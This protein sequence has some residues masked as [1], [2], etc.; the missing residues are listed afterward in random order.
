MGYYVCR[1]VL[2]AE[3]FS[4]SAK[5]FK[6]YEFEDDYKISLDMAITNFDTNKI[7]Y[8]Q[9]FLL[10]KYNNHIYEIIHPRCIKTPLLNQQLP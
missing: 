8:L 10:F 3:I 1:Y 6:F 5:C 2:R 9:K 4:R 7:Q